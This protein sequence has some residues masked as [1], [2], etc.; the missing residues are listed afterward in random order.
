MATAPAT[1][2]L[3]PQRLAASQPWFSILLL[4]PDSAA[5]TLQ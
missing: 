5:L 3:K 1:L 4:N 2:L